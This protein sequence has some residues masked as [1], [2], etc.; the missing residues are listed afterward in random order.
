[1]NN[2]STVLNKKKLVQARIAKQR[3]RARLYAEDF[4]EYAF[5]NEID[6]SR[7][8]NTAFHKEWHQHARTYSKLVIIA[9]VEHAKTQHLGI[10]KPLHL[11]GNNP[12][13]CIAIVSNT[14]DQAKKSLRSIRQ[15]I[16]ENKRVHDIFPNLKQSTKDGDPWSDSAITVE[17]TTIRKDPSIQAVGMDTGKI[18]G[19][20]LDV[21]VLDDILDLQNTRTEERRKKIL[22]LFETQ[23]YTRLNPNGIILIIGT[24]WHHEDFLHVLSGRPGFV[25]KRY[26]AVENP[27][28]PPQQ[29]RPVWKS[30]WPLSRLLDRYHN[31]TEHTFLRKYLCRVRVDSAG[32][33]RAVWVERMIKLGQGMTFIHEPPKAQGGVRPL[34][35][36]TGVDLG[37]GLGE[38]NAKTSI[39][40]H[41]INDQGR[42]II[43]NIETGRW[44]SPEIL[45]RLYRNY[46][47]YGSIIHVENNAGQNFLVQIARG[48]FPVKGVTTTGSNKHHEEFGVEALAVTVRNGWWMMPSGSSGTINGVPDEGRSLISEMLHYD[49]EAHTGDRLMAMWIASEAA[50]K[51]GATK[52]RFMPTQNR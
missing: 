43:C 39:F 46:L 35:C 28:D 33:F 22:E 1:M 38:Q 3:H 11:L 48:L 32:R 5:R 37:V 52:S 51:F 16:V 34:I 41:A 36:F 45:D 40:T 26:S 19:S 4:V 21:I 7:I 20:R 27:D 14:E 18:V 44:T 17:R 13:L 9:P 12:N 29:W 30:Q 24:P 2:S 49:P 50:R 23:I 31:T 25:V 10:G 47:A 42:S 8:Q 15:H 6:G